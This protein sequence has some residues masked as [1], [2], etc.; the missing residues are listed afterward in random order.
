MNPKKF[1]TKSLSTIA[2]LALAI[3]GSLI[4]TQP[5]SAT[6]DPLT[7]MGYQSAVRGAPQISGN[8]ITD[9]VALQSGE[10]AYGYSMTLDLA[11]VGSPYVLTTALTSSNKPSLTFAATSG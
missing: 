4:A 5:A 9:T 8:N 1:F 11:S 2:S 10:T 7:T 3:G 6:F